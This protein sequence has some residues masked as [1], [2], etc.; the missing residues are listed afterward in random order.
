MAKAKYI[1]EVERDAIRVGLSIKLTAPAIGHYLGRSKQGIYNEIQR[2]EQDGT[3]RNLPV[4][5]LVEALARDMM[6]KENERQ[7]GFSK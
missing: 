6:R 5:F 2:L 4:P 3:L 1:T 7:A